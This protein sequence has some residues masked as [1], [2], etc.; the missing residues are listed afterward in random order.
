MKTI[1]INYSE[2]EYKLYKR[3]LAETQEEYNSS[4]GVDDELVPSS[5]VVELPEFEVRISDEFAEFLV[6][7]DHDCK[8]GPEDACAYCGMLMD[9]GLKEEGGDF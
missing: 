5:Y 9:L 4:I 1:K 3:F 6:D 7:A 2:Y 8:A